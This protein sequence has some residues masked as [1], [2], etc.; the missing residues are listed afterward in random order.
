MSQADLSNPRSAAEHRPRIV[1][2]RPHFASNIGSVARLLANFGW[3]DLVLVDPIADPRSEEARR[4][5]CRGD[6]LLD[7]VRV[8]ADLDMALADCVWVVATAARTGGLFRSHAGPPDE[9]LRPAAERLVSGPIAVMFGPEPSGLSTVD[10]ARAH[11]L[12]H[13]P[14]ADDYPAL[15][16]AAA[17]AIVLAQLHRSLTTP[18]LVPAEPVATFA[19]QER[20]FTL[21][22]GSLEDVEYLRGEKADSLMH[23]LRQLIVRAGPTSQEVRL[24]IG[25][26]RQLEWWAKRRKVE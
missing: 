5:A 19:E 8:V 7:T 9:V 20:M 3:S 26:A 22:R 10:V 25:L 11:A 15:N 21:L 18:V 17:A 14:T 6:H 16:L 4:L 24:L 13:I 1:L 12:I 2:V 23:G